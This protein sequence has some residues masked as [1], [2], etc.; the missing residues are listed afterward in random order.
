MIDARRLRR[1]VL[2]GAVLALWGCAPPPAGPGGS[3]VPPTAAGARRD[4]TAVAAGS[5]P[6]PAANTAMNDSLPTAEAERV[7]ATIPEPLSPSQ[8]VPP[9]AGTGTLVAR[10][11]EAAYDTLRVTSP[12]AGDSAAVPVPAPTQPLGTNQEVTLAMPDTLAAP[13]AAA[14]GAGAAPPAA[15]S[16]ATTD[17]T[18][19]A[20]TAATTTAPAE[21]WR[22]QVSAPDDKAMADSRSAAAQSLL[23]VPMTITFEKG[24]Y[25]VRTRDC[26]ARDAADAL[27]Q[28]AQESGFT[29]AFLINAS[30]AAAPASKPKAK[31]KSTST[32]HASH[33]TS[34]TKPK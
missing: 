16:S 2:A 29:G 27:K 9:P 1:L 33:K 31:P 6:V 4:S 10:A 5:H 3:A 7:L 34:S 13:A 15:T 30:A 22:V 11:P 32:K 21:C 19:P 25:K 17:T 20:A 18:P 26:L 14:T 23:M 12:N 8:Q 24:L 28:R